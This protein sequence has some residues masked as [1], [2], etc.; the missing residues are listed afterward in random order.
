MKHLH[1]TEQLHAAIIEDILSG[2]FNPGDRIPSEREYAEVTGTSR[3]TVRRAYQQLEASGI[4]V[5]PAGG[6]RVAETFQAHQGPLENVGLLTTLPHEFS[7]KFVHAVSQCC[8]RAGALTVLGIPEPDTAAQQLHLAVRMASRGIKDLIV[9]G[10]DRTFDFRVFQRLRILGVNL[11]FFDQVI[12]GAYA[13]YVGL[14]NR[15]AVTALFRHA[16]SHGAEKMVFLNH[17]GLTID[18]NAEREQA[19]R[20]LLTSSGIP[21][22]VRHLPVDAGREHRHAF[23]DALL[24]DFAPGTA[25]I[26]VNAPIMQQLFRTPPA[27]NRLYCVDYVPQLAD[28]NVVG[29]RQP[30]E[31][32]AEA[33]VK[34]LLEQRRKGPK[35]QAAIKRFTGELVEQ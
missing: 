5:R 7:G 14:D 1:L 28:M 25:F 3:I 2:K 17:S 13:D 8:Q 35:W 27:N 6:A 34:M 18:T 10:A 29:Y 24:R 20:E 22:E 26:G 30:I 21:G 16:A 33:A 15:A 4:I 19:F 32:M 9:W 23:A 12:P 11:V 31:Q